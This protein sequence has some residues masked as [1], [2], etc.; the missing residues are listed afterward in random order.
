EVSFRRR[1][2]LSVFPSSFIGT[3]SAPN[4]RM[5]EPKKPKNRGLTQHP[6]WLAPTRLQD[7]LSAKHFRS[8]GSPFQT[9][10]NVPEIAS[11]T[12][13][14]R[15]PKRFFVISEDPNPHGL[16]RSSAS[17]SQID[18]ARPFAWRCVQPSVSE[19]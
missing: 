12:H 19:K 7:Y 13:L 15:E 8:A 16:C 4:I 9:T 2:T 14:W 6:P 5:A 17:T 3:P 1:Y 11:A 10:F 18:T